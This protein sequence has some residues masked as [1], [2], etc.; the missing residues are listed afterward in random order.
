MIKLARFIDFHIIKTGSSTEYLT[1][2]K[3]K[4]CHVN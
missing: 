4:K 1:F 2:K 3:F